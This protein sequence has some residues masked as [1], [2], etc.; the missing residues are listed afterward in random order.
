MF[1]LLAIGL[2]EL[3]CRLSRD[4]HDGSLSS[5]EEFGMLSS[6]VDAWFVLQEAPRSERSVASNL[7]YKGYQQCAPT[8]LSSK[9]WSDRFKTEVDIAPPTAGT[10]AFFLRRPTGPHRLKWDCVRFRRQVSLSP[11][12]AVQFRLRSSP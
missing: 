7:E 3:Y 8:Y 2:R 10:R 9:Q 5:N 11:G 12:F 4:R 1:S 6:P